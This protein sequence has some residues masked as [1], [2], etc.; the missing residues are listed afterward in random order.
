MQ[1]QR[2]QLDTLRHQRVGE[3][4]E[5]DMRVRSLQQQLVDMQQQLQQTQSL[6]APPPVPVTTTPEVS[7][8]RSTAPSLPRQQPVAPPLARTTSFH[9]QPVITGRTHARLGLT[10][11]LPNTSKQHQGHMTEMKLGSRYI[12]KGSNGLS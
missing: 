5:A 7:A 1:S 6:P 11:D 3:Q 12:I 9:S 4:Q 2:T 8:F 10:G